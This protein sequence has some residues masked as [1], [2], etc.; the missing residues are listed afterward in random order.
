MS[1]APAPRQEAS[2]FSHQKQD[3]KIIVRAG[4]WPLPLFRTSSHQTAPFPTACIFIFGGVVCPWADVWFSGISNRGHSK[5]P[6]FFF[7]CFTFLPRPRRLGCP[8]SVN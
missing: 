6:R 3:E 2:G 5:G 4:R 7:A 1:V 8:G